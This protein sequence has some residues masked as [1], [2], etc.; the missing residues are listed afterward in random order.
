MDFFIMDNRFR[1]LS[2]H[3]DVLD[4]DINH[5]D[6]A[7]I[8]RSEKIWPAPI[9][10]TPQDK[11]FRKVDFVG[12]TLVNLCV[13]SEKFVDVLTDNLLT[14]WTTYPVNIVN[15]AG[16]AISG[17]RGLAV[18]GRCG[19]VLWNESEKIL[20]PAPSKRGR[21]TKGWRGLPFDESTWDG[22]DIFLPE[23]PS[24]FII[25]NERTKKVVEKCKLSNVSFTNTKSLERNWNV[26]AEG[27]TVFEWTE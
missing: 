2:L 6:S 21:D 12:T 26:T 4:R 23:T 20:I 13:I 24:N 5:I 7:Q 18:T 3:L 15:R 19:R 1:F 8:L 11:L 16:K 22:S 9:R 17:Y 25:A 14:G 10:F 27:K